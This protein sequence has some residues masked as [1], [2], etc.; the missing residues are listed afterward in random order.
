MVRQRMSALDI[1]AAADELR[2]SITGMRLQNIYDLN[3]KLFLLKFGQ[4]DRKVH[5]LVESGVRIHITTLTREKPKVP[6]QF[7]LKL[8]KHVRSWRLDSVDQV[9]CDRTID[10]KFGAGENTFHLIVEFFAKGNFILTD[11][12]YNIM[13]LLRPHKEGDTS[14]RV[15]ERYPIEKATMFT[16]V[17]VEGLKSALAE[18]KPKD[19]LRSAVC[20][21]ALCYGSAIVEH[22]LLSVGLKPN[23]QKTVWE[24]KIDQLVTTI[25]SALS[26]CSSWV[27]LPFQPGGFLV[28]LK[29]DANGDD[30]PA[31]PFS[32]PAAAAF[33]GATSY[34]GSA[35]TT[36]G[37][38][39]IGRNDICQFQDFTPVMMKQFESQEFTISH[40]PS[41][42]AAAE[43]FFLPTEVEKIETHNEKKEGT[44]L[45]K[46]DKCKRDHERRIEKLMSEEETNKR[47]AQL[48]QFHAEEVEEA[49]ELIRLALGTG[50]QWGDLR[51]V[52]RMRQREGHRVANII[53]E[54]HLERKTITVLL[55]D[56]DF[57]VGYEEG[58]YT[59]VD[60]EIDENE[61]AP[62]AVEVDISMSAFANAGRYYDSKKA[63]AKKLEKTVAATDKALAGAERKGSKVAEKKGPAKK[64]I[65]IARQ[66]LWFE[67]FYWFLTTF[68]H[69]VV[70]ARDPAQADVLVRR[71]LKPGDFFVH[72]DA[73]GGLPCVVKN[74]DH[75]AMPMSSIE[76]AGTLTVCRSKVWE[77][78]M[79]ISAWWV[80]ASQVGK[81]MPNGDFLG[82]GLFHIRGKK[83]FL[84][85]MPLQLGCALLFRT[86]GERPPGCTLVDDPQVVEYVPAED[87]SPMVTP[88]PTPSAHSSRFPSTCTTPS[89]MSSLDPGALEGRQPSDIEISD[90][91]A[92]QS[93]SGN[94]SQSPS[95]TTA[96]SAGKKKVSAKDRR[97]GAHR[98][99]SRPA[100]EGGSSDQS[101]PL[102]TKKGDES[103]DTKSFPSEPSGSRGAKGNTKKPLPDSALSVDDSNDADESSAPTLITGKQQQAGGK[104]KKAGQPG[105]G[106]PKSRR[107]QN[108]LKK[109]QKKYGEQDEEDREA[110][111]ALLGTKPAKVHEIL[112]QQQRGLQS[113]LKRSDA[114][115]AAE[116]TEEEEDEEQ[117][118]SDDEAASEKQA[119]GEPSSSRG[120][121]PEAKDNSEKQQG[122][123]NRVKFAP[124]VV[125]AD[126]EKAILDVVD[127]DHE[128]MRKRTTSFEDDEQ[129]IA[130]RIVQELQTEVPHLRGTL[131]EDDRATQCFAVIAPYA[132]LISYTFKVKLTPGHEKRGNAAKAALHSFSQQIAASDDAGI[133]APLLKQLPMEDVTQQFHANV[134]VHVPEVRVQKKKDTL[135][136]ASVAAA[137]AAG[138]RLTL[139]SGRLVSSG[140]DSPSSPVPRKHVNPDLLMGTA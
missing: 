9:G 121:T 134:K 94:A 39:V 65:T 47:K 11:N 37:A 26:A 10:F 23:E 50:I 117:Q 25:Y 82:P 40:T 42:S 8:R 38:T 76:E 127:Q 111:M 132:S 21:A 56:P 80:Y 139:E 107:Q 140:S 88:S 98:S 59:D 89:N 52:L 113:A 20:N 114:S 75:R 61:V 14:F 16:A 115:Q 73:D 84:P 135:K 99:G 101:D 112:V 128:D 136:P 13:I 68:G 126:G 43:K 96:S 5:V 58:D 77:T 70:A 7:T 6:S 64:E 24:S 54:L 48:L 129:R 102:Q 90:P 36:G 87:P 51:N 55:V 138:S 81:R 91:D 71:Y 29:S 116:G 12:N 32:S 57:G 85:A 63:N 28:S 104:A 15:R 22:A 62:V 3:S 30:G 35:I 2:S 78:K 41:F 44:A 118:G 31:T 109:I 133:L 120:V 69:V 72:S 79:S 108:K 74:P 33:P 131:P 119:D 93:P 106:M 103:S 49:M 67:K 130:E 95:A 19:Q 105:L 100:G 27:I 92:S 110:A 137:S 86:E 1:K 18:S 122:R 17:T 83:N 97:L 123:S 45:S 4:S 46:K 60:D 125:S 53:H 124:P 66:Q 34:A